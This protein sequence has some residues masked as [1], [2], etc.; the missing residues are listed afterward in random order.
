[1]SCRGTPTCPMRR[2]RR[3][4]IAPASSLSS[5]RYVWFRRTKSARRSAAAPAILDDLKKDARWPAFE[6]VM[7]SWPSVI[8]HEVDRLVADF[9][10]RPADR[11]APRQPPSPEAVLFQLRDTVETLLKF[12]ALVLA[13]ALIEHGTPEDGRR[14]RGDCFGRLSGGNWLGIASGW[15]VLVGASPTLRS[16]HPLARLFDPKS[17]VYRM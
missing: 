10:G 1:S 13:R 16:L 6:T 4:S 7:R 2:A 15:A 17:A 14:V 5:S 3:C 12:P 9:E 11:S 8:A